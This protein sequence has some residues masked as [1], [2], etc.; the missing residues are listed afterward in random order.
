[1]VLLISEKS[2]SDFSEIR[3]EFLPA[4]AQLPRPACL[5]T[6][7]LGIDRCNRL[8]GH[9]MNSHD[10]Q[11]KQNRSSNVVRGLHCRQLSLQSIALGA[12]GEKQMTQQKRQQ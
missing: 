6:T 10:I 3:M 5:L 11:I 9:L 12:I 1:M 8:I 2:E 7:L 4:G